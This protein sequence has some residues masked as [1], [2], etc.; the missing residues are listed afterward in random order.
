MARQVS[1]PDAVLRKIVR[2]YTREAGVRGLEKAI[3][4][5]CR[6]TASAVTSRRKPPGRLKIDDLERFLGQPMFAED[7]ERRVR[8]P[9]VVQG[10]SWTPHGGEVL[11]IEAAAVPGKGQLTLT[12]SVGDVMSESCRIAL[13]YLRS[14]ADDFGLSA[15]FLAKHD[16]HVHFPAGAIPKDGP[17][18]GISIACALVSLT[19]D[20]MCPQDLTMTGELTLVGEVLP[21][22]GVREKVL[23]AR[24]MRLRRVVLPAENRRDVEEL[25]PEL[26]KGLEFLYVE[27]FS[28]VFAAVFKGKSRKTGAR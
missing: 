18:A 19:T 9:G 7:G 25:A 26:V 3:V 2:L 13:S 5:I 14:H 23:A 17:S 8:V 4:K 11:F 27:E 1:F 28:E 20:R 6:K 12:G 24:R 10:L 21:V 16:F 15:E 22:G